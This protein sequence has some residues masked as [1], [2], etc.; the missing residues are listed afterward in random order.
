MNINDVAKASGVS[1]GTVSR[2]FNERSDI[3]A[4]TRE[5]VLK[6]A[7]KMG[8]VPNANARGLAKGRTDCV[9]VVVPDLV[10]VFFAEQVSA[11]EQQLR[12]HGKTA[13]LGL[14]HGRAEDERN[15]LNR[16]VSGQVDGIIMT[17]GESESSIQF[18]NEVNRRLPIVSL[19]DFSGL[20]CTTLMGDD[21]RGIHLAMNHLTSLKHRHIAFACHSDQQWSAHERLLA[22]RE[23]IASKGLATELVI[24]VPPLDQPTFEAA[25]RAQVRQLFADKAANSPTAIVAFDDMIAIYLI[26][27]LIGIGIRVPEEVSVAGF[28]NIRFAA[29]SE[30]PL[31]SVATSS[32][33]L[34]THAVRLLLAAIQRKMTEPVHTRLP[35]R[36]HIRKS[37]ATP[38]EHAFWEL[39]TKHELSRQ[40]GRPPPA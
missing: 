33:D 35:M 23:I 10:N 27:A 39:F 21:R 3:N 26:R 32:D 31:T 17:P 14:T 36:L 6:I 22:Y 25:L 16:M 2:A 15:I 8:Y 40:S 20:Q 30:V 13:I 1:R 38:P 24:T 12:E 28:D 34:G 19:K 7:D 29:M 18:I 5:R 11:I 4:K 9:G 37:T